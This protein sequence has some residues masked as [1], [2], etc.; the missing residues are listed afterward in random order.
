MV[1]SPYLFAL[2]CTTDEL[3]YGFV[4]SWKVVVG[5]RWMNCAYSLVNGTVGLRIRP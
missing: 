3:G 5:E 4:T 1:P 2:G